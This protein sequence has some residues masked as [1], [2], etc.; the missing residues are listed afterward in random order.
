MSYRAVAVAA[1]PPETGFWRWTGFGSDA[2]G[3]EQGQRIDF[4]ANYSTIQP[5][6]DR[7]DPENCSPAM[8]SASSA[9]PNTSKFSA[10]RSACTDLGM[11]TTP[12]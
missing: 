5:F 11:Q 12:R 4:N 1:G 9:K 10:I 8:S 7:G 6:R 2:T 3:G